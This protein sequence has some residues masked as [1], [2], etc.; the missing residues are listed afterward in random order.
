[1]NIVKNQPRKISKQNEI[2]LK[3]LKREKEQFY[4][5]YR[6]RVKKIRHL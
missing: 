1:M 4:S 5:K 3:K 2:A 6:P